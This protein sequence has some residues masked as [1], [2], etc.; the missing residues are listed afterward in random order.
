MS[1]NRS[2][3]RKIVYILLIAVLL[4]PISQLGAPATLEDSGGQL[5]QIRDEYALGQSNLGDIDPASETIRMATLGLRGIAVS[6]LWNKANDYKKR[7]DWTN[8]RAVLGQLAKLQPYFISFWRY[9]SWNL[10]YNVSVELDDVRDRYYYVTRGIEFLKEG[11]SYNRDSPHLLAELGWF[12]GN[13]I[14][15]ADEQVEYRRLFRA[16][17]DFQTD[18][19]DG[20][21]P[22]PE[23]RDNWLVSRRVY[24]DS[25]STVDDL[26]KSLGQK[27]PTTFFAAPA[28]SQINYSEAI[29]KEGTFQEKARAAWRT[30][31][32]MWRDY[33]NRE[34]RSSRGTLIRLADLERWENELADLREQLDAIDPD[35]L[36]E[37]EAKRREELSEETL[38]AMEVPV[39]ERT[40]EQLEIAYEGEQQL[41]VTYAELAEYIARK[42]PENASRARRLANRID[43]ATSQVFLINNNRQVANY[44]YWETRTDFEQTADAL[45]ARELAYTANL[46]F[47]EDADLLEARRLFEESFDLWEKVFE[48]YPTLPDDSTTGADIMEYIEQYA[49]VLQQLDLSLVD[50]EVADDF[51]LW[52]ILEA[53]DAE[54][55]FADIIEERQRRLQEEDDYRRTQEALE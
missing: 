36:A 53:N 48:A 12:I 26:K 15:R 9:Q 43:E 34:M 19:H 38:A 46:V 21:P 25:I 39:H 55:R 35:A 24:E 14:G 49:A 45:R 40:D 11:T 20:N 52:K 10:T 1:D 18:F 16:D 5:A 29:E 3:Y 22:P 4:F 17:E 31:S 47:R 37:L 41:Q 30:A 42:D 54:R 44:E 33:G 7:E 2:F 50:D 13:K 28:M 27:N 23:Q 32:N 8:F 6:L 51:P